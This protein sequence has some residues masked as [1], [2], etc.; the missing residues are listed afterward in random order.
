MGAHI[1]QT[2]K[3]NTHFTATALLVTSLLG[4]LA[5]STVCA[6]T[7]TKEPIN[8]KVLPMDPPRLQKPAKQ[9]GTSK[10]QEGAHY[11][12]QKGDTLGRIVL[13]HNRAFKDSG[14]K[15]SERLI[16]EANPQI[17]AD[18]LATG[19][20][21]FIPLPKQKPSDRSDDPAS[22]KKITGTSAGGTPVRTP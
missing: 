3:A 20:R 22:P 7:P 19:Q 15:T 1:V 8:D 12:V 4:G 9:P 10:T 18:A 11:S 13:I 17:R 2:M 14:R 5:L 6:A 16:C 21:L